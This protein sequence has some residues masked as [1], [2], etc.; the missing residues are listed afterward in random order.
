MKDKDMPPPYDD[1]SYDPLDWVRIIQD[2]NVVLV[3]SEGETWFY[4]HPVK[5]SLLRMVRINP[6]SP[7]STLQVTC[8]DHLTD[9]NIDYFNA[10]E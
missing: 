1:L 6:N 8:W 5:R 10:E 9:P 7:P 3:A 2:P 4:H